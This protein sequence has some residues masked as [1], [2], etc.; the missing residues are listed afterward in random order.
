M[1]RVIGNVLT[2]GWSGKLGPVVFRQRGGNTYVV[3]APDFSNRVLSALQQQQV[4]KFKQAVAYAQHVLQTPALKRQY[5]QR[6]DLTGSVYHR[7]IKDF[8]L[9]LVEVGKAKENR[10][11]SVEFVTSELALLGLR[12]MLEME[13]RLERPDVVG[14]FWPP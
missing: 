12:N 2:Q 7:A 6:P 13:R 9:G 4:S 8:M 14:V 10:T 11:A 3:K 1:A 5:E